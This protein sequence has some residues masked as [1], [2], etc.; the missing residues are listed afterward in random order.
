M[1]QF[2]L[3]RVGYAVHVLCY[4]AETAPNNGL[5]TAPELSDWMRRTWPGT[6]DTYLCTV[7]RRLARSGLLQSQRGFSG[8]YSLARRPEEISLRDIV[9]ALDGLGAT[10]CP[11]TPS[12]RCPVE[13]QC[14]NY[15]SLCKLQERC[16]DWL[17]E[18][19]V[20]ELACN[21]AAEI[22]KGDKP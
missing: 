7:I 18:I 16:A 22:P 10:Q 5:T 14:D 17:A 2:F 4:M 19:S 8:G 21:M 13:T 15:D 1:F 11:L 12:G 6:S 3:R 9:A 20:S